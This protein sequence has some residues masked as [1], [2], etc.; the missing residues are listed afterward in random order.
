MPMPAKIEFAAASLQVDGHLPIM[1]VGHSDARLQRA[2]DQFLQ[3]LTAY[4]G[5][6]FPHGVADTPDQAKLV[7]RCAGPGQL[8]QTPD[9]DESYSLRV[10]AE[11]IQLNAATVVGVLRG[12]ATLEQLVQPG[13]NGF[14]IP[15]VSIEDKP[16]FVWR[17]LLIDVCRH[18]QPMAVIQRNLDAMA[19]V[20]L[21]V[22]H[23]HL[24]EDQGFRV[25]SRRFPRLHEHGSD[26]KYFTQ[27][28]LRKI[29]AYARDR[30]IRVVP[31]FDMPGHT[32]SWLVGHPELA[33]APGPYRIERRWGVFDPCFDPT[34]EALYEFL[35]AFF[36]EMTAIFPD[37]YM[38]IG[39]DEVNGKQ[40]EANPQIQAFLK[41]E[42]L[43]DLHALQ[44]YFN[45][46]VA[47]IL[48]KHGKTMVGWDEILHEGLPQ[49]C[50][51]Q[52]W[53]GSESLAQAIER[54]FDGILSSGFYLDH[55]RPAS[56]HYLNELQPT[57][58]SPSDTR[59]ARIL[60]GEACMWGEYVTPETIDSR[61]WP[62]LAAIAERLWSP[63]SIKDVD[64]MYRRLEQVGHALDAIGARHRTNRGRM[65]HR[66]AGRHPIGALQVLAAVVEPV[67]FYKR[68][69]ARPYTNHTPLNRLVDAA[70]PESQVA[71]RFQL[72][73]RGFL[74]GRSADAS[75][76]IRRRL[77][78]WRDNHQALMSAIRDAPLLEEVAPVSRNLQLIATLG[79]QAMDTIESDQQPGADWKAGVLAAIENAAG[80]HAEV[81]IAVIATVKT[82]V[83]SVGSAKP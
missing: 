6:E 17:G 45:R 28:Q 56:F 12:L 54:G 51:V 79:L 7:I 59:P 41:R 60:G 25:E 39:G 77:K 81:D 53:R 58:G 13:G 27:E 36:S 82:L 38:H 8:V 73:V 70:R 32:T 16:R 29:V 42:S 33:A 47:A 37:P 69:A 1:I 31:E 19:A 21:N 44:A 15:E 64:D 63:A 83:E 71:R 2:I 35:D 26:G 72:E 48:N 75:R 22:L 66:L 50:V 65:L 9:E 46:R 43:P 67:K 55:Q 49:G 24:T 76:A 80:P 3:H 34:R 68:S 10:T 18:W 5:Q 78:S 14:V 20:K 62:R 61:I 11:Q 4:T 40:W 30:G 74:S 57:G 52:S 23:L